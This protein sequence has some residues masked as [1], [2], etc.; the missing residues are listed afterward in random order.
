M[1]RILVVCL[2]NTC[3]SPTLM[4][5]LRHR[6]R[7][8]GV[9]DLFQIESA[10]VSG[11]AAR[12]EGMLAVAR[13][14]VVAAARW[15]D[16]Q[17]EATGDAEERLRILGREAA[18]HTTRNVTDVPVDPPVRHLVTLQDSVRRSSKLRKFQPKPMVHSFDVDDRG[19]GAYMTY[20]EDE[21][22]P[23]VIRAYKVQAMELAQLAVGPLGPLLA[24][25]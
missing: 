9:S 16:G 5:L 15:L 19:Y 25:E 11:Q 14:A 18:E 21:N 7:Q 4:L 6:A 22:H 17:T 13:E 1:R 2:G 3:R 8:V 24:L 20:G 23:E 10:G 12:G